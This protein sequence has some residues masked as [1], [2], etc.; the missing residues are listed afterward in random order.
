M[1]NAR[2]FVVFGGDEYSPNRTVVTYFRSSSYAYQTGRTWTQSSNSTR[3]SSASSSTSGSTSVGTWYTE[4]SNGAYTSSTKRN[5]GE[6]S[7]TSTV[8]VS[9]KSFSAQ[10]ST[11]TYETHKLTDS[12]LSVTYG[13]W[14]YYS[15]DSSGGSTLTS[16]SVSPIP[17]SHTE[18]PREKVSK[19]LVTKSPPY[20]QTVKRDTI[21]SGFNVSTIPTT[22]SRTYGVKSYDTNLTDESNFTVYVNSGGEDEKV[23]RL[24][25]LIVAAV[26]DVFSFQIYKT[27]TGKSFGVFSNMFTKETVSASTYTIAYTPK[28]GIQAEVIDVRTNDTVNDDSTVVIY[29][30]NPGHSTSNN[31]VGLTRSVWAAELSSYETDIIDWLGIGEKTIYGPPGQTMTLPL[32][33]NEGVYTTGPAM[34]IVKESTSYTYLQNKLT[35]TIVF[36]PVYTSTGNSGYLAYRTTTR[37]TVVKGIQNISTTSSSNSYYTTT[38]NETRSSS[39]SSITSGGATASRYWFSY[40]VTAQVHDKFV[41][42]G[43]DLVSFAKLYAQGYLGFAGSYDKSDLST[44]KNFRSIKVNKVGRPFDNEAQSFNIYD[45][46]SLFAMA[47]ANG[48]ILFWPDMY[49]TYKDFTVRASSIS[50]KVKTSAE[51]SVIYS[52]TTTNTKRM[53]T[54]TSSSYSYTKLTKARDNTNVNTGSIIINVPYTKLTTKQTQVDSVTKTTVTYVFALEDIAETTNFISGDFGPRYDEPWYAKSVR[55]QGPFINQFY[56]SGRSLLGAVN[57]YSDT[58]LLIR[59]LLSIKY[60]KTDSSGKTSSHSSF[61][62]NISDTKNFLTI[63]KNEFMYIE[64]LNAMSTYPASGESPNYANILISQLAYIQEGFRFI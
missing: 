3:G 5:E 46:T 48:T 52:S 9:R 53:V 57:G 21:F 18:E 2:K 59:G 29:S 12:T 40:P 31:N 41:G 54:T 61:Y 23:N 1:G 6:N 56:V 30:R 13:T 49:Q 58:T 7:T 16:Q 63:S 14:T 36:D 10:L 50:G 34:K 44:L 8:A 51:L 25:Q 28:Y 60:T 47:R 24:P 15:T 33:Y 64:Y 4:S 32:L 19:S 45:H 42:P 39:F 37:D 38:P 11:F 27:I 22:S 35:K 17:I 20:W 55:T 62:S 43:G 26:A